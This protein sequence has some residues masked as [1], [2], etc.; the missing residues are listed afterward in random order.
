MTAGFVLYGAG[1]LV[2]SVGL[3]ASVLRRAGA[4]VVVNALATL[5]VAALPLDRSHVGDVAHGT[6]ATV[7]YLSLA[8]IPALCAR[9]LADAGHR[10]AARASAVVAGAIAIALAATVVL[11]AKGLAQRAGLTLGDLWLAAAGVWLARGRAAPY[12]QTH[13]VSGR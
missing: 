12:R 6:A 11:D 4:A 3:R 7:G 2:G 10:R 13:R 1:V 5:A 8:A 9:P